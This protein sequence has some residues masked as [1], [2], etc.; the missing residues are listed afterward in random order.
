MLSLK[1]HYPCMLFT[2]QKATQLN[3]E[4]YP[5][6]IYKLTKPSVDLAGA[7]TRQIAI[8]S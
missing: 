2:D 7:Y 8:V 5:P 3:G 1:F 4:H 6:V